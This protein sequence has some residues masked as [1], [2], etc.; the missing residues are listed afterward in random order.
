MQSLVVVTSVATG[1][2]QLLNAT[3]ALF[4]PGPACFFFGIVWLLAY[5]SV[6]LIRIVFM[7]PG[8]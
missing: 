1:L 5:A 4:D 6:T 8:P 7:R 3:G 2:A